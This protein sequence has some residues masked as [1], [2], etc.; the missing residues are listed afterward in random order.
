[1][2]TTRDG[3]V[4]PC[5]GED[6]HS[7]VSQGV[8]QVEPGNRQE[9]NRQERKGVIA[10][11][12]AGV[13]A[14]AEQRDRHGYAENFDEVVEQQVVDAAQ[15]VERDGEQG[16]GNPKSKSP[17]WPLLQRQALVAGILKH[18]SPVLPSVQ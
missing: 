4:D 17:C 1:M 16:N 18:V 7:L 8:Q 6:A 14:D 13:P 11:D 12:L 3:R 15:G 2:R 10:R 5:C 9:G